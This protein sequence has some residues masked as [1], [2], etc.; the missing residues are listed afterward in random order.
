MFYSRLKKKILEQQ[1]EL[2]ALR[3]FK[4][5][6]NDAMISVTLDR[7][8]CVTHSNANFLKF[9]NVKE[10][11]V[12]GRPLGDFTPEYVSE[13]PCYKRF[14]IAMQNGS[15]VNDDYRLLRTDQALVWLRGTWMPVK[16]HSGLVTH[17]TCYGL[18][19]TEVINYAEKNSALV[20]ALFRS[21]AVIE[22]DLDGKIITANQHFLDAVHYSLQQVVGKHHSI[23]CD[24]GYVAS[25]AYKEFWNTLEAGRFI[26]DRFKRIDSR[27][28]EVWLEATY[29]PVFDVHGKLS[30]VVKFAT[31]V[32][33]QVNSEQEVSSAAN[34]AYE[35][36]QHADVAA[37]QGAQVVHDTV[38]TMN[39]IAQQ[40]TSA[41]VSMEAL[42][43]QSLLISSIVQTIG[44]IAQQTNLLAL[45]AAI[46]AA[47]AGEQGR[48]FAVVADEVR[49]LAARTSN[50]TEDIVKVVQKNQTLVNQAIT[51]MSGSR[52]QAEQGLDLARQAGAV[53]KEIQSGAQQVVSAVEQFAKRL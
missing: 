48:G 45:N 5:E 47:R 24:P 22:F 40:M 15:S 18:E 36:S 34:T 50:A 46:E 44:G 2:E 11:N 7:K 33:D 9:L 10:S 28:H 32:T 41:A 27:G 29:N 30:K 8:L 4:A 23:F 51:N 39:M 16:D 25:P 20:Q 1:T 26:A 35:I 3:S 19:A 49:Q 12:I 43:E 38:T 53:I 31:A 6:I 13:L 42:G 17:M 21:T 37:N 52:V 14:V